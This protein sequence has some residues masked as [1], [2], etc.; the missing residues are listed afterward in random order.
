MQDP[1][2]FYTAERLNFEH[3]LAE[4]KKQLA[5]SSTL[6]L[7]VFLALIF[8]MYFFFGNAQGMIITGVIGFF[9]FLFLVSRHTDLQHKRDLIS[10]L[11]QINKPKLMCYMGII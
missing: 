1:L 11:I 10:K 8:G 3:R 5:L 6:R 7:F 4:L 2:E 9:L